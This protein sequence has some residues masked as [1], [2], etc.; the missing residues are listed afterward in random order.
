MLNEATIYLKSIKEQ[1][2]EQPG[3]LRYSNLSCRIKNG[4]NSGMSNWWTEFFFSGR[5]E[6]NDQV[7]KSQKL[8]V[9]L[10]KLHSPTQAF[11]WLPRSHIF[12]WVMATVFH[13]A[14]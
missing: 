14:S 8:W 9:Q 12:F 11:V 3:I 13:P 7:R 1:S 6:E 10:R 5:L 2:S 4:T